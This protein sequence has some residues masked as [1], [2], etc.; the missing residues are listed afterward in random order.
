MAHKMQPLLEQE[1]IL[2]AFIEEA[3]NKRK[4]DDVKS[5]TVNLKEIRDEIE[6]LSGAVSS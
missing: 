6:H 1:A 5:L 3:R 2:E 4:F